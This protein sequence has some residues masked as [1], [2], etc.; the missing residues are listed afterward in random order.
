[1]GTKATTGRAYQLKVEEARETPKVVTGTF[2]VNSIPA[3]V[4][5]DSGA[6]HSFISRN[7][8]KQLNCSIERLNCP[9]VVEIADNRTIT[10][11]DVHCECTLEIYGEKFPIDLI[12]IDTREL[13]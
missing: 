4:L 10:V 5:F 1:S 13:G 7:F 3:V 8:S 9:L 11:T 12:L 6:T 2:S